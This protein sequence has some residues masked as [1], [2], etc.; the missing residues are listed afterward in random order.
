MLR[1][2]SEVATQKKNTPKNLQMSRKIRNSH[3]KCSVKIGV[4]K[5]FTNFKGKRLCWRLFLIKLET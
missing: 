3:R 1:V 4:L 5:S 2:I